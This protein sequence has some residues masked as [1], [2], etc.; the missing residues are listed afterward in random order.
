MKLKLNINNFK[1]NVT[2]TEKKDVL[3]ILFAFYPSDVWPCPSRSHCYPLACLNPQFL[4]SLPN[5][6]SLFFCAAYSSTRLYGITSQKTAIFISFRNV[7]LNF[8]GNVMETEYR[9]DDWRCRAQ[10]STLCS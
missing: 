3:T 6:I 5:I 7:V 9:Q 4:S 8:I 1:R 2:L 10:V